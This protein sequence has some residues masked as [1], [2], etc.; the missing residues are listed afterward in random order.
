[1]QA[2]YCRAEVFAWSGGQLSNQS[3]FPKQLEGIPHMLDG[4]F[5][6]R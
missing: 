5:G 3:D 4:P 6:I 2:F 1:V